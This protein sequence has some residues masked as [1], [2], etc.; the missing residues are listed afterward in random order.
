MGP[1][2]RRHVWL[3]NFLA[4][5]VVLAAIVSVTRATITPN[6][7]ERSIQTR[8]SR[9][10]HFSHLYLSPSVPF[11]G[12]I[13]IF[14]S[15]VCVSRISHRT[16]NTD[17][18]LLYTCS[19]STIP[20]RTRDALKVVE[21]KNDSPMTDITHWYCGRVWILYVARAIQIM[22]HMDKGMV[23]NTYGAMNARRL[24]DN[25][26]WLT[27][28]FLFLCFN[29]VRCERESVF[30]RE[31]GKKTLNSYDRDVFGQQAY[32]AAAQDKMQKKRIEQGRDKQHDTSNN[33]GCVHRWCYCRAG[34]VAVTVTVAALILCT[35]KSRWT[36]MRMYR[37]RQ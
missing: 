19:Y 27:T 9:S 35:L 24:L 10:I 5:M 17:A 8:I 1:W 13:E 2:I 12:K 6:T 15:I 25:K 11:G 32:G 20:A 31:H 30:V 36:G 22:I 14:T 23:H 33:Y 29:A 7:Y 26:Y 18:Y 28:E 4:F 16:S 34:D 3:T 37:I 21:S